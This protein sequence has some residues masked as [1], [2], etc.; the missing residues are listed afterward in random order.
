MAK[1]TRVKINLTHLF[2]IK[3]IEIILFDNLVCEKVE[4]NV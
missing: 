2:F 1:V 3:I 4:S